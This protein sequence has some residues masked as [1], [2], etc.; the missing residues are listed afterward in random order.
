MTKMNHMKIRT[1]SELI[2]YATFEERF[3]YLKLNGIVGRQTFGFDRYLN[4]NFYESKEWK[5]LRQIVI[6]RDK[7]LDLSMVGHDII[8]RIYIHHM[9]PITI[10]DVINKTDFLLNPEYVVCTSKITHLA[11]HYG[12]SD[13]LPKEFIERTKNDTCPWRH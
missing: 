2:Q 13:L 4:Q 3:E 10:D 5:Q 6:L 7:G 11:I 1:Y 12:N 9:N 8:G